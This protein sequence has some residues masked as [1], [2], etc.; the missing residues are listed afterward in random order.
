MT[1]LG[2]LGLTVLSVVGCSEQKVY[3]APNHPPVAQA[4]VGLPQELDAPQRRLGSIVISETAH[5]DG[6]RSDDVDADHTIDTLTFAWTFQSVAEGSVLVDTDILHEQDD[7]E[8]DDFF[9]GS[10][11]SFTP[12]V[13]GSYRIQLV[14]TDPREGVSI[15][16][17]VVVEA[18]PPSDLGVQLDWEEGGVDFDLHLISPS[19]TYF[20]LGTE[21]DCFSW[22]PNPDWGDPASSEDNPE[23]ANDDD[24][25]GAGPYQEVIG[26]HS[27]VNGIYKVFVHYYADHQAMLGGDSQSASATV[28]MSAN[29]VGLEGASLPS[30]QLL[31]L[32]QVWQVGEIHWPDRIF[33]PVGTISGHGELGGPAYND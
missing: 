3:R 9:E 22:L 25:V 20:D 4:N 19:G 16:D 33:A 13:L 17:V 15:E 14:V 12:D 2:F 31:S 5:L 24:A 29:G 27:P 11:A 26:L 8:T 32:G 28:A 23:L 30:P 7:P 6:S 18:V 1:R 21:T 10:Q